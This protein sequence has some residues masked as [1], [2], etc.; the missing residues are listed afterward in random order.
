MFL[1]ATDRVAIDAVGIAVLKMLGSN[2]A[3][4]QSKIFEQEQIVRA[5]DLGLGCTSP[6]QI[7]LIAA[8]KK[9]FEYT[10]RIR[11]I[12]KKG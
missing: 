4:M 5:V 1:C 11:R 8:D 3:V 9:S 2:K 10:D 7:D 12:L 6:S